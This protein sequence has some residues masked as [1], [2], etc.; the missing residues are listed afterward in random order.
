MKTLKALEKVLPIHCQMALQRQAAIGPLIVKII[1]GHCR[2]FGH[3]AVTPVRSADQK[4]SFLKVRLLTFFPLAR[5]SLQPWYW[6]TAN[7]PTSGG[8]FPISLC[9]HPPVLSLKKSPAPFPHLAR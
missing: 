7:L 6:V 8:S 5:L 4:F 9:L 1:Q 3:S 2:C